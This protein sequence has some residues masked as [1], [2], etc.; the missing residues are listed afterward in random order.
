MTTLDMAPSRTR[1][2]ALATPQAVTLIYFALVALAVSPVFFW[3]IP[4]GVDIVNHWARL[5]LYSQPP[6]DPIAGLYK[7]HLGLIPNLGVDGLYLALSS[8]LSPLAVI[9]LAWALCI[10]LPAL[11]AFAI[12][13][14]AFDKPSPTIWFVPFLSYN[15]A[16]TVGLINFALGAGLALLG[17]AYAMKRAPTLRARDVAALNALGALIFFCHLI[18]LAIYGLLLALVLTLPLRVSLWTL[19]K[20][21][22]MATL[23]IVVP[24]SRVLMR[25]T[26]PAAYNLQDSSGFGILTAPIYTMTHWD[27]L[28]TIAPPLLAAAG[29]L[30]GLRLAP[31][32]ALALPGFA[33]FAFLV[34]SYAGAATL[35]DTRLKVYLWYFAL[36]VVALR[37]DEQ[38]ERLAPAIAALAILATALRV[39]AIAPAWDDFNQ[40]AVE[41]RQMLTALPPGSRALVTVHA[42]CGHSQ[43][44]GYLNLTTFAVIDR[45]SFVN[46]LFAQSGMQPVA[47]GDPMLDGGPTLAMDTRWLSEDRSWIDPAVLKKPWAQAF[48]DWRHHFTHVIDAY[49]DC[50]STPIASGLTRIGAMPGFDLYKID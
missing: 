17:V 32:A 6:G 38:R 12:H 36:A 19:A 18:A 35:I 9:K 41:M 49:A 27:R 45:R 20:R 1:P 47:P 50:A 44:A 46:T 23:A 43:A 31:R 11:G 33:L 14:A 2:A 28:L 8:L 15:V 4:R 16:T 42:N 34:P 7:V 26:S 21:G 24:A 40:H 22:M 25:E 29:L 3:P 10:A 5:T 30:L 39:A 48:I 37:N 13:R